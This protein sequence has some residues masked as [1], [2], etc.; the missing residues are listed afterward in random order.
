MEMTERSSFFPTQENEDG[1]VCPRFS[2]SANARGRTTTLGIYLRLEA[3]AAVRRLRPSRFISETL[4]GRAG[5][6]C[7]PS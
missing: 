5:P 3:V 7:R 6:L 4:Q 2:R 1:P